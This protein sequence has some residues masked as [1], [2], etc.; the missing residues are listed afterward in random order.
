MLKRA[1]KAAETKSF[2]DDNDEEAEVLHRPKQK[3]FGQL[4]TGRRWCICSL[5]DNKEFEEF[6][7]ETVDDQH[8]I[9][10]LLP[11]NDNKDFVLQ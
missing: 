9:I 5:Y 6:S 2:A 8:N 1:K 4:R 3:W 11:P 7:S 10:Y